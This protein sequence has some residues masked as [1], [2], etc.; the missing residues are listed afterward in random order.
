[1]PWPP[2]IESSGHSVGP[3]QRSI[4]TSSKVS[5]GV[6]TGAR[7]DVPST[8]QRAT[9]SG[10][11]SG[12]N[13]VLLSPRATGLAGIPPAP[14]GCFRTGAAASTESCRVPPTPQQV[15]DFGAAAVAKS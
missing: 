2:V 3:E 7:A 4:G 9:A 11:A 10:R 8:R 15:A 13:A 14:P 12:Q 5:L 1:M 6:A